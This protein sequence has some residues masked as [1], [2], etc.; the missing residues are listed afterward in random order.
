MQNLL[1][2]NEESGLYSGEER[3]IWRVLSRVIFLRRSQDLINLFKHHAC[4][5][6]IINNKG[7]KMNMGRPVQKFLRIILKLKNIKL[8]KINY[9]TAEGR[10]VS[11]ITSC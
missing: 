7:A 2:H 9:T 1:G 4:S 3:S 6:W 5:G 11:L 10:K 8:K